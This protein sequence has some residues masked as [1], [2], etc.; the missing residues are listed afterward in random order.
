[1]HVC[2]TEKLMLLVMDVFKV[3]QEYAFEVIPAP[4]SFIY[5]IALKCM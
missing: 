4:D 1:M 5:C 3:I 2:G